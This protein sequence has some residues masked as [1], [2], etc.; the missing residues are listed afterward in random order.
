MPTVRGNPAGKWQRRAQVATDDYKEGIANPRR[1]WEQ[2]TVAAADVHKQA[3]TE[4]LNRGAFAAGVKAAGN[5]KWQQK[6]A[7][8]GADRFAPGVTEAVKDYETAVAPYL[9]TIERTTLPARGPKGDPKNI[10]RVEIIAKALRDQK[11]A[12]Q[13]RK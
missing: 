13:G 4:A 7:G 5:Q 10:K 8:K 2:A 6:A 11:L 9:D 1:S 3:T 12:I